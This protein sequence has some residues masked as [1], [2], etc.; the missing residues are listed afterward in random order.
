M[1]TVRP[2]F[3]LSGYTLT[4]IAV[5]LHFV[6]MNARA[7]YCSIQYS[8]KDTSGFSDFA[9]SLGAAV[10]QFFPPRQC[11]EIHNGGVLLGDGYD[12]VRMDGSQVCFG[13]QEGNIDACQEQSL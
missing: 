4:G 7:L 2:L 5:C 9:P 3:S 8:L 1:V 13:F 11:N 12:L 10:V 6:F